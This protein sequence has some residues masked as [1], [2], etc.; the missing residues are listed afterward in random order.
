MPPAIHV[1]GSKLSQ[2]PPA[3]TIRRSLLPVWRP[4]ILHLG[5]VLEVETALAL[6]RVEPVDVAPFV[7]EHL[8]EME[9]GKDTEVVRLFDLSS[10]SC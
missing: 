9:R 2:L 5:R 3:V 10:G 7:G 1:E 8:L 4:D 6:L